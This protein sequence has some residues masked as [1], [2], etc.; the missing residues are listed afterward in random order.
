VIHAT[1]PFDRDPVT[2]YLKLHPTLLQ[3]EAPLAID[4]SESFFEG[5]GMCL[6][7]GRPV[8]F[9]RRIYAILRDH[10]LPFRDMVSG[11]AMMHK[12]SK[13]YA[14]T[15][16]YELNIVDPFALK[17]KTVVDELPTVAVTVF[18]VSSN[19]S[20]AYI[21]PRSYPTLPALVTEK[22]KDD[23]VLEGD[24]VV[25]PPP[26]PEHLQRSKNED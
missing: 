22:P 21:E 12:A 23:V 3:E 19:R 8:N 17:R 14:R 7:A 13:F 15:N 18:G 5:L 16:F 4:H 9:D 10:W 26:S 11:I 1:T 2:E 20:F 24:N 25:G 6:V